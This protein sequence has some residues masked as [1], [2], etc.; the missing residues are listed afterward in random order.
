MGQVP[1][2]QLC[3][4]ESCFYPDSAGGV[5]RSQDFPDFPECPGEL[6]GA[7]SLQLSE[8]ICDQVH[9]GPFGIPSRASALQLPSLVLLC[10]MKCPRFRT[11]FNCDPFV[12]SRHPRRDGKRVDLLLVWAERLTK[13]SW[14]C[15]RKSRE[16]QLPSSQAN[17]LR[18]SRHVSIFVCLV[19]RKKIL[20][21]EAVRSAE[22]WATLSYETWD[23][24]WGI[25]T[26]QRWVRDLTGRWFRY[27]P[28]GSI[29]DGWKEYLLFTRC[30]CSPDAKPELGEDSLGPWGLG[31]SLC[32]GI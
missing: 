13:R 28:T 23:K 5:S 32:V 12:A 17:T 29:F 4:F 7:S 8:S 1:R 18:L 16:T 30:C 9:A 19:R 22:Q 24:M 20:K 14:T 11:L 2:R 27:T 15:I 25:K 6:V 26:K 31:F 3:L 21:I 10:F